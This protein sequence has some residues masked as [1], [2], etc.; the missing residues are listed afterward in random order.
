MGQYFLDAVLAFIVE[1]RRSGLP[2]ATTASYWANVA[3]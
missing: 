1:D 3:D 2:V